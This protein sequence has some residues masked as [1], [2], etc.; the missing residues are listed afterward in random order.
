MSST[1]DNTTDRFISSGNPEIDAVRR[2]VVSA[3]TSSETCERRALLLYL[4]I[5]ALQQQGADTRS[6]YDT[7]TQFHRLQ[8]KLVASGPT[9]GSPSVIDEASDDVASRGGDPTT[10]LWDQEYALIDRGFSE[11]ER[12]QQS[13]RDGNTIAKPFESD[14]STAP[15]GDMEAEWPEFQGNNRNTGFSAAPGPRFGR[16]AWKHP[17]GLGWYSRPV[18]EGNR[19]YLSS[20]GM[21]S[22]CYC[23]DVETGGEVWKATQTHAQFGIYKYPGIASTPLVLDK[24]VI[25]REINSHGGNEGQA[26]N[27]VYLD[28][29][30]GQTRNRSYAGHIDYRTQYAPVDANEEY[31]VYPFG[32]HD[33]YSTPAICQNLNRLI[34]ADGDNDTRYWDVNIGDI[35]AL[36]EP[37][38]A[39]DMAI[40]G[41]VEGYLY[42]LRLGPAESP[43][44]WDY[45]AE[46]AVNTAVAVD[47]GRIYFGCNG[48]YLYCLDAESGAVVWKVSAG[49]ANPA[50]RKHFSTTAIHG[51][52][53]YVGD[54]NGMLRCLDVECGSAIWKV[55]LSD[56]VRSRP[57]V[58]SSGVAAASLDGKLHLI[59]TSGNLLW[60]RTVS[61]HPIYAD[62]AITDAGAATSENTVAGTPAIVLTDSNLAALCVDLKGTVLW[63]KTLLDSFLGEDG[64]RIYTD[65]L[66]GGTFYQSKP[67]AYGGR[68]Y[69]G[70]PSGFLF[71]VDA[72]SGEEVWRFEMGAAI[73]VGPACADGR[74][75]AGQQG[76]ERF[77]YCLSATD[78]SLLWKQTLPGGWVWGSATV[79]EGRVYIP[80]VS[81]Y[82]VCLDAETG[83]IIWMYPT[84]RSIPAEPAVDGDLVFFGSW[85]RTIYAFDKLTGEIAWK[86]GGVRLDSGTLLV[87]GGR[88]Y[89]PHHSNIFASF[90]AASGEVIST[91]NHDKEQKGNLADFNATPALHGGKGFFSARGGLGLVG[92]PLF[93][94]VY[95]VDIQTAEVKWTFPDGGGLSAPAV[96]G[97]RVYV[98]SGNTPFFYCL[99][100][101]TGAPIWVHRLGHRTE[102][103][104]LCI[105][106]D[107]V[108]VLSA[109][110]YV[111]A[112]E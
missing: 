54:A 89:A 35:D 29:Q 2:E 3:P 85:S 41:T 55:E 108:Y 26:R 103:S 14:G 61:T 90:D 52:R 17:V 30:T 94:T 65:Q 48:G 82:A 18:I 20:P 57:V 99:D 92:A 7:D 77:F 93:S 68:L 31:V 102:E 63:K 9:A 110:G 76:G 6:F 40:C 72:D 23:V 22:T 83:H 5:G 86:Q 62:L 46:G 112:I 27:L 50:A 43:I 16:T 66:S 59:S 97:G 13:L 109:D 37:V 39:G 79:D 96:A 11:I 44:L 98:A 28:K 15:T 78:G 88:I 32:V 10:D 69:F 21:N 67:T 56:W 81:G 36:A 75:F 70:T 107:K 47:G 1:N 8:R 42:A 49:S 73:S 84:A 19:V 105:Y 58:T 64:N 100:E 45:R 91:G 34:C 4:W 24:T 51:E 33:I 74:I 101:T 12:I 53:L 80:T 111:H 95:C 104:T 60:S 106:R 87:E 71:A 25:L 38:I